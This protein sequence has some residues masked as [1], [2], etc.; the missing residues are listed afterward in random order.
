[1]AAVSMVSV[2]ARWLDQIFD[3]Q[4]KALPPVSLCEDDGTDELEREQE[5]LRRRRAEVVMDLAKLDD[6]IEA[7]QEL[8]DEALL[9]P[10]VARQLARERAEQK[11]RM[12]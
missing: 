3:E 2:S 11:A 5:V 7:A 6:D 1:M 9:G 4:C 8:L 10:F 12:E